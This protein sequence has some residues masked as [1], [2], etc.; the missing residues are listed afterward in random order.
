MKLKISLGAL[1]I[2]FAVLMHGLSGLSAYANEPCVYSVGVVPQFDERR[3][4]SVWTPLLENL[5]EI[6]GCELKLVGSKSIESYELEIRE[7]KFD[8]AY[9]NPVQTWMGYTTQGY[10]PL[11]RSASK[12]L[13]GIIVVRK[14]DR[15]QLLRELEGEKIAFPSPIAIGATLLPQEDLNRLGVQFVPQY[16]KTHSSVYF[17]VAKGL[18]RAGGGVGRTLNGQPAF[19]KERLRIIHTTESVFPHAF[20][21][22]GRVPKKMIESLQAAWF[23]LWQ[24]Q[25]DLFTGIPMNNPETPLIEDYKSLEKWIIE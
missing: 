22:H 18:V 2:S 21:A 1:I 11:A 20:V 17:H 7:G 13:N 14:N 16:V 10:L 6:A 5:G 8:F 19:I 9:T 25:P 15:I 12:K 3:I 4:H 23:A 24:V